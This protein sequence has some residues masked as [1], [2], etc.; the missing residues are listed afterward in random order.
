MC[1]EG[2]TEKIHHK[3]CAERYFSTEK[4]L[5]CSHLPAASRALGVEVRASGMGSQGEGWG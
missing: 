1:S 2:K 4:Q 5:M 3:D